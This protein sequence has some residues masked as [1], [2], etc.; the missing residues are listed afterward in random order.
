MLWFH[1]GL[2]SSVMNV[3]MTLN[4]SIHFSYHLYL[5]IFILNNLLCTKLGLMKTSFRFQSRRY[6]LNLCLLC[7]HIKL[8][9]FWLFWF[10]YQFFLYISQP[11]GNWWT[12]SKI[13]KYPRMTLFYMEL[14]LLIVQQLMAYFWGFF[15]DTSWQSPW[16]INWNQDFLA[17]M[18]KA[19]SQLITRFRYKFS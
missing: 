3:V 8:W 4:R 18:A 17:G 6:A 14:D 12:T 9:S 15:V 11:L 16:M 1:H 7:F 2:S 10:W 19:R 5:L 13:L